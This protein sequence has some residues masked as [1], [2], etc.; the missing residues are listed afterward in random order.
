MA[1]RWGIIGCGDVTEVKSGPGFQQAD[2]SELVAVM[3]R[4]RAKA[5]DYARRHV[6]PRW[7]DDAAKLIAD[8]EVDAVYVATPPGSHLE[9]ALRVAAAGKPAYVEKPMARNHAECRRMVDAFAAARLPL[10]VAYYRRCL[11]RFMRAKE[12]IDTGHLGQVTAV[13]YQAASPPPAADSR[14]V[15]GWHLKAEHSGGGLFLDVGCHTLDILDYMLGPLSDVSGAAANLAGVGEV[16]DAVAMTFRTPAGALGAAQ[17]NYASAISEDLIQITGSDARLV[18]STFGNQPLRLIAA[19]GREK[20]FDLPNPPHIQ[21]PLIQSIVEELLGRGR[22]PSHG[23]SAA[24]TAHVM[25]QV[26]TDY[27]AGRDDAFWTRPHT[28]PGRPGAH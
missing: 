5:E 12:L 7:Y 28:W 15:T 16:E 13:S 24:R 21:Q 27:Y 4:T 23:D 20:S 25:D 18:L 22:C 6:V 14:V 11:P 1:I 26:L 3:R 2:G 17:W 10:F 19:E 9:C 8:P